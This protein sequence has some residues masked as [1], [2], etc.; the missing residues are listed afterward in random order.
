MPAIY[1]LRCLL[2]PDESWDQLRGG[3]ISANRNAV[4][5]YSARSSPRESGEARPRGRSEF[6]Q[7]STLAASGLGA[8]RA[9]QQHV[10]RNVVAFALVNDR[11]DHCWG[12]F[13]SPCPNT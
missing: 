1:S 2:R 4:T 9:W 12:L 3:S 7:F 13:K 5:W 11:T 6:K 8:S 10:D